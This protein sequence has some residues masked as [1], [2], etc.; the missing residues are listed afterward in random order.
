MKSVSVCRLLLVGPVA[1]LAVAVSASP[2]SACVIYDI[3]NVGVPSGELRTYNYCEPDSPMNCAV[4]GVRWVNGS[5]E[6]VNLGP[7]QCDLSNIRHTVCING[8]CVTIE[9]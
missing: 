4:V 3:S 8:I 1:A 7:L 5:V 9:T 6:Y 2:A